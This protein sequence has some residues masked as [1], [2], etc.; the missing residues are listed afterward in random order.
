[1]IHNKPEKEVESHFQESE[2]I[3]IMADIRYD[4]NQYYTLGEIKLPVPDG[5]HYSALRLDRTIPNGALLPKNN[6]SYS[7]VV[8]TDRV[9]SLDEYKDGLFGY[10]ITQPSDFDTKSWYYGPMNDLVGQLIE[11]LN[12]QFSEQYGMDITFDCI[13][14]QRFFVLLC[15]IFMMGEDPKSDDFWMS[16]T[17]TAITKSKHYQGT[18][19]VNGALDKVDYKTIFMDFIRLI[20]PADTVAINDD[21]LLENPTNLKN[22]IEAFGG[23]VVD[24]PGKKTT[25]VTPWEDEQIK[26]EKHREQNSTRKI[27]AE[28]RREVSKKSEL[29]SSKDLEKAEL[30]NIEEYYKEYA[31]KLSKDIDD[32]IKKRDE[33]IHTEKA[34][35]ERMREELKNSIQDCRQKLSTLNIFQGKQ[36]KQL[37]Q[38]VEDGEKQLKTIEESIQHPS[39]EEI[40]QLD[41]KAIILRTEYNDLEKKKKETE[42]EIKAAFSEYRSH[43][44]SYYAYLNAPSNNKPKLLSNDPLGGAS[45]HLKNRIVE[46]CAIHDDSSISDMQRQIPELSSYSNQLIASLVRQLIDEGRLKKRT[47]GGRTVLSVDFSNTSRSKK[48]ETV[49]D[50]RGWNIHKK[51]IPPTFEELKKK[52]QG[53]SSP[54]SKKT[55]TV[56]SIED[57]ITE[58]ILEVL[59]DGNS[60]TPTEIAKSDVYLSDYNNQRIASTLRN[61]VESGRI[62]RTVWKGKSYFSIKK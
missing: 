4:K 24:W 19:F 32:T 14:A 30:T 34:N 31:I 20:E 22:L 39:N 46:Y 52:M 26:E 50:D 62:E 6:D 48:G 16:I 57:R 29:D 58:K 25:K 37:K 27:E 40:R 45:E 33:A 38:S 49:I 28:K 47:S 8:S 17:F 3:E 55:T 9:S 36:K 18:A 42:K 23:T 11:Q 53:K 15:A 43:L 60:R 35:K 13:V 41:K 61:L 10:S 12:S 51:P 1:M 5:F 7:F 2:V 54:S 21:G 59:A 44:T 56:T